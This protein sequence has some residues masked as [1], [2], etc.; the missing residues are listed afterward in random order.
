MDKDVEREVKTLGAD[1]YKLLKR[2]ELLWERADD[3]EKIGEQESAWAQKMEILR[4]NPYHPKL[5]DWIGDL[6]QALGES[7]AGLPDKAP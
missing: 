4:A 1:D 7:S 5:S 2:P 6:K 3:L